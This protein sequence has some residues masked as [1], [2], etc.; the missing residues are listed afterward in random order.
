MESSRL[1]GLTEWLGNHPLAAG[2]LVAAVALADALPVAGMLVP[3]LAILLAVGALLGLGVLDP[4][5]ILGCAALGAFLGDLAG[6]ALGRRLGPRLRGIW[7]FR[8]YPGWIARGEDLFRRRGALGVIVGRQIGAIRPFVPAVAGML[9]MPPARFLLAAVPSALLF[10]LA[11]LVP[12]WLLARW[13]PL[14]AAVAG[15]VGL[16]VLLLAGLA[17]LT[18]HG[19]RRLHDLLAP[20]G[21]MWVDRAAAWARA[22]PRAGRWLRGLFDPHA[23]ESGALLLLSL[24]LVAST[25]CAL[26]GLGLALADDA[27]PGAP[28]GMLTALRHPWGDGVARWLLPLTEPSFALAS[29]LPALGW[30]ALRGQR[31]ALLHLA[32]LLLVSAVTA[33]V[34]ALPVVA[35]AGAKVP[36]GVLLTAAG[37]TL[38]AVLTADSLPRRPR[39]GPYA[40]AALLSLLAALPGV[41][42]GSGGMAGALAAVALGHALGLLFGI[43]YRRHRRARMWTLP[44]QRWQKLGA[45]M[46]AVAW[47]ALGGPAGPGELP[48]PAP[49]VLPAEPATWEAWL[50]ERREDFGAQRR[51]PLQLRWLGEPEQLAGRLA[52]AGW[53]PV[54]PAA[55]LALLGMLD[56]R[57]TAPPPPRLPQVH[58]GH[59]EALLL[60]LP[61]CRGGEWQLRLWPSG[62]QSADGRPLYLGHVG[63][64][65]EV[66]PWGLWRTW[67]HVGDEDRGLRLVAPLLADPPAQPRSGSSSSKR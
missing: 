43:A 48:Q 18:W 52:A 25:V 12:G 28:E 34:L 3:A 63:R 17:V 19:S 11:Y 32:G 35:A 46:L 53:E 5:W 42:L 29:M 65:V 57:A 50:P 41:Y 62:W 21:A 47:L 66:R 60:R 54:A 51:W 30:L 58:A 67:K 64:F 37:W 49:R 2:L 1:A 24:L 20:R 16:L 4:A 59:G 15:R 40:L 31:R 14:I 13:W 56:L 44:L 27:P 39:A 22:H 38:L 26:A 45:S 8:R 6:Y 33:A 7:P 10:A 55:G 36:A 9:A 23:P 61:A